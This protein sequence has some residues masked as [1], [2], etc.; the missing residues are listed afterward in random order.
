MQGAN[1]ES[2]IAFMLA[3]QAVQSWAKCRPK[4]PCNP[5]YLGW[6]RQ[7]LCPGAVFGSTKTHTSIH[8]HTFIGLSTISHQNSS[9]LQNMWVK[10]EHW[11]VISPLVFFSLYSIFN[12][13]T[14]MK[15][16]ME[17][18]KNRRRPL[19]LLAIFWS[20]LNINT[21]QIPRRMPAK[22]DRSKAPLR[23][24]YS[25]NGA[26]NSIRDGVSVF[27]SVQLYESGGEI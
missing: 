17:E 21:V 14:S 16:Q 26:A 2:H 6:G 19:T 13:L 24:K 11:D 25:C 20:L 23:H 9:G 1:V 8:S 4:T 5:L 15:Y 27:V 10:R 12:W 3:I 22:R 7:H 18:G